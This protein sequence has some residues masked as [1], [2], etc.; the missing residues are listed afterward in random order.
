MF[1]ANSL[2]TMTFAIDL[3]FQRRSGKNLCVFECSSCLQKVT[4]LV[5][6]SP[7]SILYGL[8]L[9][10]FLPEQPS[11]ITA[12]GQAVQG[13]QR[14]S[15]SQRS[16]MSSKV[17]ATGFLITVLEIEFTTARSQNN[18]AD[19]EKALAAPSIDIPVC[20][21]PLPLETVTMSS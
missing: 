11:P 15:L 7:V 2:V 5:E 18:Q 3:C 10:P 17:A 4:G 9:S 14:T 13:C 16:K 8:Q 21:I 12:S 1:V 19:Q 20:A 6:F